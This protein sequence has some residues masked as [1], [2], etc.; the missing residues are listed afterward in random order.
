MTPNE[1]RVNVNT[2]DATT[3]ATALLLPAQNTH[4][5]VSGL[6]PVSLNRYG[7]K[8]GVLEPYK[9]PLIRGCPSRPVWTTCIYPR[10]TRGYPKGW[11]ELPLESDPFQRRPSRVNPTVK[12]EE[13]RANTTSVSVRCGEHTCD[14]DTAP[15]TPPLTGADTGPHQYSCIHE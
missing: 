4:S 5:C 11:G 2:T 15:L 14:E 6:P 13:K 10:V 3:V 7:P 9:R 1:T 12:R 8:R